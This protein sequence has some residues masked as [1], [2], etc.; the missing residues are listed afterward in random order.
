MGHFI[1][2]AGWNIPRA[3]RHRFAAEGTQLQRYASRLNAAE[4]NSSFYRAHAFETYQRWAAAVPRTF[5]FS[6]KIPKVISHDRRLARARDPLERFLAETAGLGNKRGPLLLQLPPSFVFDARRVGRFF[7]L[8]RSRYDGPVACEPRHASWT[9]PSATHLLE[10]ARVSRVAAD[11]PRADGL[12]QPAGWPQLVYYRWHGSP[13]QYFSPY[14][15][16]VLHGLAAVIKKMP[17][18]IDTWCIFDNTGSG[19]AAANAVDLVNFRNGPSENRG[20]V[21]RASEP[22]T[23]PGAAEARNRKGR[24]QPPQ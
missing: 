11:P 13:R 8:M 7:E 10:K 5:R 17:R 20:R 24:H 14:G 6:I 21:G 18:A 12:D 16:E 19:A 2:T 1:G 15:Q 4:I 3:H 23:V 9:T 22:G